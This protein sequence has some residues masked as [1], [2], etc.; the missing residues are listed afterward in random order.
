MLL[1]HSPLLR[2]S[3]FVSLSP[4]SLVKLYAPVK[5]TLLLKWD[6][7]WNIPCY[8]KILKKEYFKKAVNKRAKCEMFG[9]W[10]IQGIFQNFISHGKLYYFLEY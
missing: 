10:N 1:F 2:K 7:P 6:I 8:M 4:S 3:I 5:H 9:I